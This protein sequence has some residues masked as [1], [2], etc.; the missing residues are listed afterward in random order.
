[1]AALQLVLQV[2]LRLAILIS[3]ASTIGR[4]ISCRLLTASGRAICGEAGKP[5]RAIW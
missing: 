2:M 4:P 5:C 3:H 1:M